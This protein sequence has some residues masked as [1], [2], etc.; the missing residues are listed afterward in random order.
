MVSESAEEYIEAICRLEEETTPV[1][2]SRLA[3]RLGISPASVSEMLRKLAQRGLVIYQPY[4]GATLTQEGRR[5]ALSLI[6]RHR[7]WERFL[8]DI[9]GVDWHLVHEEACRLEHAASD[10]VVERLAKVL[11]RSETCPHGR[12]IPTQAGE[13]A[14]E[15]VEPLTELEAGNEAL[16]RYVADEG[17]EFLRYLGE[18]GLVPESTVLVEERAPFEGLLTVRVEGQQHI[19]GQR[20]ASLVM[21]KPL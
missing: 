18:L 15:V 19:L 16:V 12:P 10:E 17:E 20:A 13:T 8:T 4:K 1:A 7:L 5:K 14:S 11:E 6:R 3:E 2:T 9:L 21:V